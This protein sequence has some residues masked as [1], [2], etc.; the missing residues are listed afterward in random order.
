MTPEERRL[1]L[2]RRQGLIAEVARKQ[3]LRGLAEALDTEARSHT[4]A[5][6]S[7]QLVAAT[8]AQPGET[9]GAA[10]MG[11]AAFTASLSQLAATAGAAAQD[12]ARQTTWQTETLALA[13][14]RAKRLAEREAEARAALDAAKARRAQAHEASTLARKLHSKIGA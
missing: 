11:R 7:Q 5:S 6:R 1:V 8:A 12:A 2:I 3:A 4:L 14:T 9:I 10:L 13:E